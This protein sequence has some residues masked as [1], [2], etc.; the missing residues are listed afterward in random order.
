MQA[1]NINTK[2]DKT[3]ESHVN[4]VTEFGVKIRQ[5]GVIFVRK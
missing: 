4:P 3:A 2:P 1:I 5:N